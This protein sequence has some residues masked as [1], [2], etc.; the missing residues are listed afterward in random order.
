VSLADRFER[1]SGSDESG[2]WETPNYDHD[3]DNSI[4]IILDGGSGALSI[5]Q[6]TGR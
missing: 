6:Q 4:L 1:I 5:V 2:V 3:G